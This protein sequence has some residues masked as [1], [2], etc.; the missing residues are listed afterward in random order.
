VELGLNPDREPQELY[1][2]K[3]HPDMPGFFKG[4]KNIHEERGFTEEA[5]LHSECPQFKCAEP[6]A[7]CCCSHILFNQSDFQAQQPALVELVESH[8]HIACF[9]PKF[10]CELNFIEQCWGAAKYQYTHFPLTLNEAQMKNV[11]TCLDGVD[12]IKMR[13]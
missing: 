11:R 13:R 3:D 12:L 5:D 10:H 8:G 6:M 7:G 2:P 9:Y 4:M 1:F